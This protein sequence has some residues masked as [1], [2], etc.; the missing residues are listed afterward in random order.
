M[1]QKKILIVD[2]EKQL[3]SLVKLHMEMAGYG[4]LSAKDGEEALEIVKKEN[5]D[6]II[7][8]LMIPKIDGWEVCKRIR[9]ESKV[10]NTPVIML[11]ARTETEDKLKGYE[12]GTDDYVTKP[13]SP[14]EL[15]A[16][17]KRVLARAENGSSGPKRYSIGSVD[18]DLQNFEVKVKSEKIDLTEKEKDVLKALLARPGEPLN[19]EQ[20]LDIVW[21][22]RDVEY[23]NVDVHIRHLREKIETDPDDPKIIKTV[24][25]A[26]YVVEVA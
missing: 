16:R 26:G 6:L 15:V 11:S 19:R 23:G 10:G 22:D 1:R 17:V 9:S 20:L 5:P 3:V 8:D 2:D 21:N 24:K 18:I 4:V 7:L 12:C 13:F 25:G 14:R